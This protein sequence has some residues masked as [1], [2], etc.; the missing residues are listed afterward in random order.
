MDKMNFIKIENGNEDTENSLTLTEN[1]INYEYLSK[2]NNNYLEAINYKINLLFEIY[3]NNQIK[4]SDKSIQNKIIS[5]FNQIYSI[6]NLLSKEKNNIIHQYESISRKNEEKIRSL[7]SDIFNLKIRNTYLENNVE[8]LLKKEEEY[9]LIK[10]KTGIIV[11]NGTII[12]NDR[13]DNEIFILRQEN[14]NLKTVVNKN[15][16]ELN[17]F[18]KKYEKDKSNFQE[19]INK[20]NYKISFLK[21]QLQQNE[22][23]SNIKSASNIKLV[24]SHEMSKN[25]F[26]NSDSSFKKTTSLKKNNTKMPLNHSQSSRILN[27]KNKMV[28][29]A[30]ALN[31]KSKSKIPFLNLTNIN[32]N[33]TF[34]KKLLNLTPRNQ[35][36]DI[37]ICSYQKLGNK[38]GEKRKIKNKTI[39]NNIFI[40]KSKSKN[41]NNTINNANQT[42]IIKSKTV[43]NN[44]AKLRDRKINVKE[45]LTWTQNLQIN[46][47]LITSS[48]LK[49]NKIYVLNNHIKKISKDKNLTNS[50]L[51]KNELI[52]RKRYIANNFGDNSYDILN[53]LNLTS[54]IKKNMSKNSIGNYQTNFIIS[55][56]KNK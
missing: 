40:N 44:K 29:K 21:N 34:N 36:N 28:N 26:K 30:N 7:Y 48:P 8:I 16:K 46:N 20:L 49:I 27:L 51:K 10:E 32:K 6:L 52:K 54:L 35:I 45:Q 39:D 15:E 53:K 22:S 12:Y 2:N 37:K 5:N 31:N 14:S 55:T 9:K 43:T 13:K 18:K 38:S 24:T 17:E 42:N 1:Q 33:D 41:I 25:N 4:S 23:K 47:P 19:K 11:E 56:N 50:N 3:Q